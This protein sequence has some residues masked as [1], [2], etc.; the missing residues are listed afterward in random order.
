M[1]LDD[2]KQYIRYF[3]P[4]DKYFGKL[5]FGDPL[6][7][8]LE[9]MMS[10]D[11]FRHFMNTPFYP[12]CGFELDDHA[13]NS[14]HKDGK[15][16][17]L[18]VKVHNMNDMVERLDHHWFMGGLGWYPFWNTPGFHIDNGNFR[19]WTQLK[20]GSMVKGIRLF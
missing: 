19:R 15:A 4:Y 7:M 10:L 2:W 13:K 17:D 18:H 20:D 12:H 9:F 11:K 3:K 14:L 6:K 5:A 8:D 1:T 16:L